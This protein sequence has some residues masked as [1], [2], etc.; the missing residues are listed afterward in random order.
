METHE[1]ILPILGSV[2]D[3]CEG[4]IVRCRDCKHYDRMND[5]EGMCMTPD[6]DGDYA[7][8]MVDEDGF[9]YLGKRKEGNDD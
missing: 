3:W 8:W 5:D 1:V 7:R 4:E 2:P 6:D 9:C